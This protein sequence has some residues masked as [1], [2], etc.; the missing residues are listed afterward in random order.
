MTDVKNVVSNFWSTNS[1][2]IIKIVAGIIIFAILVIAGWWYAGKKVNEF[3][4]NLRAQA[5]LDNRPLY[6]NLAILRNR[7]QQLESQYG[8]QKSALDTIRKNQRGGTASV[9]KNPDKKV[10]ASY[11]DNTIDSYIPSK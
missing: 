5:I 11:F 9:F 6:D 2:L 8:V 7:T 1:T 3:A 10:V 4:A